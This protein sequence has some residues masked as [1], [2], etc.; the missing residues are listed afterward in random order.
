MSKIWFLWHAF[1]INGNPDTQRVSFD[2][3]EEIHLP[4]TTVPASLDRLTG[5]YQIAALPPSGSA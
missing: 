4:L 5:A 1:A 3:R 2:K